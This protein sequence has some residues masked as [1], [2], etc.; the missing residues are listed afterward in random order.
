MTQVIERTQD[1]K[2]I[3]TTPKETDNKPASLSFPIEW[4]K[5]RN[6]NPH[7]LKVCEIKSDDYEPFFNKCD[8]VMFNTENKEIVNGK[9]HLYYYFGNHYFNRLE[10]LPNGDLK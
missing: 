6:L 4:L 3:F 1:T 2:N 9:L 5:E 8:F 7:H 10:K